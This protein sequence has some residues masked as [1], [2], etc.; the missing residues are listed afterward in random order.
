MPHPLPAKDFSHFKSFLIPENLNE[1]QLKS[2]AWFLKDGL[3]NL[4]REVSPIRDHTGEELE[5][6][7]DSYNLFD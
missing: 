2:Y 5:L 3:K 4:F 7:F 1:I 6:H